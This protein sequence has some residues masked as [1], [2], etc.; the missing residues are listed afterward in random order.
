M[1]R[2]VGDRKLKA[3]TVDPSA[4]S[5]IELIKRKNR[6]KVIP[7]ENS[8][9]NGIRSVSSA[10][11]QGKIKI[12][13]NCSDS[14]REF[15]LYRW[16]EKATDDAPVKENDHAMDDIRYFVT[17]IMEEESGFFA[18]ASPRLQ[19]DSSEVIF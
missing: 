19:E 8:V 9:I 5:F 3:I 15:S 11:K 12:C 18:F 16:S 17:T 4:A 1:E 7:A 13:E 6:F 14:I 2:L 10:L